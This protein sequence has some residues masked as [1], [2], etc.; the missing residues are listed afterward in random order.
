MVHV[1]SQLRHRQN[2]VS[3]MTLA[4]VS[5]LLLLQNGQIAGR[6]TSPGSESRMLVSRFPAPADGNGGL[7]GPYDARQPE[8]SPH[9]RALSIP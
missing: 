9:A 6:V 2:V 7:A 1:R 8:R 3:V 5:M 4:S